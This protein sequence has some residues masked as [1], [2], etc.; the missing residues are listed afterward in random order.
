MI[1][2]LF[3][4]WRKVTP[5]HSEKASTSYVDSD[6]TIVIDMSAEES[7]APDE[8]RVQFDAAPTQPEP[9]TQAPAAPPSG[10]AA[11]DTATNA[12]DDHTQEPERAWGSLR[13]EGHQT[14]KGGW[15][16]ALCG[17]GRD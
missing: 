14:G 7:F 17:G 8:V 4:K 10:S 5:A 1:K 6:E 15:P 12:D 9:S 11:P 2:R 3:K 16:R 13:E